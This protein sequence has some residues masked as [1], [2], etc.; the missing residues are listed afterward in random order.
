M[1][2]EWIVNQIL[3]VATPWP[4]KKISA[5]HKRCGRGK[6]FLF[7]FMSSIR[8]FLANVEKRLQNYSDPGVNFHFAL[9]VITCQ[10][11]T[12]CAFTCPTVLN[13]SVGEPSAQSKRQAWRYVACFPAIKCLAGF[14]TPQPKQWLSF[15]RMNHVMSVCLRFYGAVFFSELKLATDWWRP[16]GFWRP[17]CRF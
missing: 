10:I 17:F 12:P 11:W 7:H 15:Q 2:D 6:H 8:F 5:L 9:C 4:I 16:S 14:S 3:A 13:V 1:I